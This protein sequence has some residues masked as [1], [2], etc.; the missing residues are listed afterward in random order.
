MTHFTLFFKQFPYSIGVHHY[1]RA[2]R[3]FWY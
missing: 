1:V 2:T 3:N